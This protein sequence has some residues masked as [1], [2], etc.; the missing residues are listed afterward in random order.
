MLDFGKIADMSKLASEAKKVQQN[1]E[2]LQNEQKELLKKIS[3][4]LGE[5]ITLLK[6]GKR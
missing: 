1:Q 2:R 5:I 4:Q 3:G 6:E